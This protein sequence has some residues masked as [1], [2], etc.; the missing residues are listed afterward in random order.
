LARCASVARRAGCSSRARRAG[1]SYGARRTGCSVRSDGSG[2][3][4]LTRR[5]R[6]ADRTRSARHTRADDVGLELATIE[7]PGAVRIDAVANLD[8]AGRAANVTRKDRL[9]FD[10]HV[11]RHAVAYISDARD[12]FFFELVVSVV[13]DAAQNHLP[14]ILAVRPGGLADRHRERVLSR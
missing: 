3:S 8:A 2:S 9:L 6:R 7:E 12:L 4:G 10:E 14:A 5:A 1:R 11:V 13:V